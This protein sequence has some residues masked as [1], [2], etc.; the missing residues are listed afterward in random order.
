M[1]T[2]LLRL[3]AYSG[4]NN[5]AADS[6]ETAVAMNKKTTSHQRIKYSSVTPQR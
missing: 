2:V 3:R 6:S 5:V 1:F 4:K